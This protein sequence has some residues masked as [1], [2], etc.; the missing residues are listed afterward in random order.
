M[1]QLSFEELRLYPF[2]GRATRV[3]RVCYTKNAMADSPVPKLDD[4]M[5]N[6]PLV[7]FVET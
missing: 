2:S 1:F 7:R 5:T 3:R 4:L 6:H